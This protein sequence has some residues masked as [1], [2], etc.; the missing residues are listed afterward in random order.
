MTLHSI[1]F[2]NPNTLLNCLYFYISLDYIFIPFN[3]EF[4]ISRILILY[5]H[6]R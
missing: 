2:V 4:P 5:S 6:L 1:G 3:W